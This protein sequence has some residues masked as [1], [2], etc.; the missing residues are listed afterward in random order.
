MPIATKQDQSVGDRKTDNRYR[1]SPVPSQPLATRPVLV[2]G[3]IDS[4]KIHTCFRAI[5][6]AIGVVG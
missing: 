3:V 5:V 1:R 4:R 6:A 2:S